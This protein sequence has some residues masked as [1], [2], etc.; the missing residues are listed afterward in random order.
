MLNVL[1]VGLTKILSI[2]KKTIN[3]LILLV[4]LSCASNKD[5][6]NASVCSE[7]M[8]HPKCSKDNDCALNEKCLKGNCKLTCRVDNDCFLGHICINHMCLFGCQGDED[9]T[10]SESCRNNKCINPCTAAPCGPNA[11]C[12][13][14]NHRASCS[15]GPGLVPSPTA[16]IACVRAP[17]LPCTEN[18][19]CKVGDICIE[20][21]CRTTCSSDQGCLS[22]ERCDT[23]NGVC[24]NLCRKDDDC[25]RGDICDNLVCTKGCRSNSGCDSDE[26]CVNS[27]CVNVCESPTACGSN[28][29]CSVVNHQKLCSCPSPLVGNPMESCRYPV[30]ACYDD[31]ECENGRVCYGGVCEN[32]C[33]T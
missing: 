3:L 1:E 14:S 33:R 9:C 13:V 24:K 4:P 21:S 17:A 10:D 28:A 22:N 12:T 7:N 23:A 16:K 29:E 8:C 11:L 26:A 25:E 15:C 18:R 5:C 32:M 20:N 2:Q 30:K 19:E 27:K 31:T 6:G